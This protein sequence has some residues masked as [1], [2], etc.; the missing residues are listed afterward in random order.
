LELPKSPEL[1]KIA[2]S[3]ELEPLPPIGTDDT[4]RKRPPAGAP[5]PHEPLLERQ[6]RKIEAATRS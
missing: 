3:S 1:P 6:L 2:K 4:D 5:V